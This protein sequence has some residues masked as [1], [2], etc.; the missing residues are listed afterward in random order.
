[1]EPP[2][3]KPIEDK[4]PEITKPNVPEP[5][6][7]KMEEPKVALAPRRNYRIR[8]EEETA[9]KPA[10]SARQKLNF[11]TGDEGKFKL[12]SH[13]NI[14]DPDAARSNTEL[15]AYLAQGTPARPS[16]P[17]KGI[18][19]TPGLTRQRKAVSFDST[20]KPEDI[21][22]KGSRARSG[23]PLDFPGKFPSPWAP[24][25]GV[26]K[27]PLSTGSLEETSLPTES[28]SKKRALKFEI[29]EKSRIQDILNE[30]DDDEDNI[31]ILQTGD[32]TIDIQSPKSAS[33]KYWKEH[34][35]TLEGLA[36]TKCDKLRQ[37]YR[38]AVE[39]AKRKDEYCVNLCE[40]LRETM[41]KNKLLKNEV[42][43]LN[44]F[45][46][47][48][49]SPEGTALSDALKI[50]A[51]K[52]ARISQRDDEMSQMQLLIDQYTSRL[53]AFE[54]MLDNRENTITDL[55]MSLYNPGSDDA[56]SVSVAELKQKLRKARTEVKELGPL[57]AEFRASKARITTL[58]KEK[59]NLEAQLER[60]KSV[61]DESGVNRSAMRSSGEARLRSRI[62]DLEREKRDLKADMRTKAAEASKERREAEKALRSEISDLRTK[63]MNE[64]LDRNELS[65]EAERLRDVIKSLETEIATRMNS[66]FAP[67]DGNH[68]EWQGKHR[69]TLQEL[70]KAKEEITQLKLDQKPGFG[71]S[72]P[73]S[74]YSSGPFMDITNTAESK[75]P[76]GTP[77]KSYAGLIKKPSPSSTSD[78]SAI[79]RSY[80]RNAIPASST[81]SRFNN[82]TTTTPRKEPPPFFSLTSVNKPPQ[83]APM[84]G[85]DHPFF[86]FTPQPQNQQA[87]RAS[88]RPAQ[89][90][91]DFES[92]SMD[93]GDSYRSVKR[94]K[95]SPHP[96]FVSWEPT[97]ATAKRRTYGNVKKLTASKTS[98]MDPERRAATEKRL[99]ERK[100]Q[101]MADKAAAEAAE[102]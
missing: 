42:K 61:G 32:L 95:A 96:N 9:L 90:A 40:K 53:Q 54:E 43:R 39:Y 58:E 70:R 5:H 72:A 91:L 27:R 7:E 30:T 76:T 20:T 12:S 84:T 97:P 4:K 80:D 49:S 66:Q 52:D 79:D 2:A 83:D 63:V 69:T 100:A 19:M 81:A 41:E 17:T 10:S 48:T 23:L 89:A 16:S 37:R 15:P 28:A 74:R 67:N 55:S 22:A 60:M 98:T 85:N 44:T 26:G 25:T 87:P 92:V 1:M 68:D 65:R 46:N 77:S 36:L 57:R 78:D 11:E 82:R 99:A 8:R 31:P 102:M 33:G 62:D 75:K 24:K 59:G 3:R 45:V 50:L 86:S 21:M 14:F 47:L 73:R 56:D 101:R 51:E 64:E 18:L 34:A 38:L 13:I 71:Q 35:Q 6:A 93:F 88:E 94:A 29:T